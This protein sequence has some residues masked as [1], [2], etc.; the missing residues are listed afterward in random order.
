MSDSA[1]KEAQDILRLTE[2][3]TLKAL[4]IIERQLFAIYT[5]AQ[6]L[7][8]LA[9]V[10]ITVTGFSGRRIAGTSLPAQLLIIGGLATVLGC[11]IWI[12]MSVMK[13]N[14]STSALS[15]DPVDCLLKLIERR[16]SKTRA[17]LLGG[18][19]FFFGLALYCISVSLMLLRPMD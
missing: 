10:V 17:Y 6:A 1:K 2:Q 9:G 16:N 11:I 7:V 13:I 12:Y 8:G 15:E 19:V 3:N 18:Y 5:R 14:W 4:E